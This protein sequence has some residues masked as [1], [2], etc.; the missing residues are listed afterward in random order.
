V[1]VVLG[2]DVHLL[3]VL[4]PLRGVQDDVVPG[5]VPVQALVEHVVIEATPREHEQPGAAGR[6]GRGTRGGG[7]H[8]DE[9]EREMLHDPTLTVGAAGRD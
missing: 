7:H 9:C 1:D 4:V 6:H 3:L 2:E 5:Q 8:G